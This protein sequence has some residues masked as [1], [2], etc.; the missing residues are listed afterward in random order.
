MSQV[1]REYH[2]SDAL[3]AETH[4]VPKKSV[5]KNSLNSKANVIETLRNL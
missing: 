2:R 5:F 3:Y 4:S 1:F